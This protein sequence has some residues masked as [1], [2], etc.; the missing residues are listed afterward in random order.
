MRDSVPMDLGHPVQ[1]PLEELQTRLHADVLG[2]Q[3]ILKCPVLRVFHYGSDHLGLDQKRPKSDHILVIDT[4]QTRDL[5]DEL[6]HGL[7][8]LHEKGPVENFHGQLLF[9]AIS[10][11]FYGIYFDGLLRIGTDWS[12]HYLYILGIHI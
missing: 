3:Q 2:F 12:V 10:P 6:G 7:E 11:H 9:S 5:V 4:R 1:H 8:S